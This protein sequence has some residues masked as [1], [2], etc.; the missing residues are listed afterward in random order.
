[1]A[2]DQIKSSIKAACGLEF[3]DDKETLLT[4]ALAERMQAT[5]TASGADYLR[6][7]Q[8]S[9]AELAELI[10][11]VTINETYFFREPE[12]IQLLTESLLP[13]LMAYQSERPLRILSLGCS[14]GEEPYSL[15]MALEQQLGAKALTQEVHI[16]GADI[17]R[18]ALAKARIGIYGD[19]AFRGL[20]P[21]W[22]ERY[23][24]R[25]GPGQYQILP[26]LGAGV[27]FHYLNLLDEHWPRSLLEQDVVFFRNVSIYFDE[28]HRR[29]IQAQICKALRPDGIL[30][31]SATETLSNDFGLMALCQQEEIFFFR[32]RAPD[33]EGTRPKGTAP[34]PAAQQGLTQ[35]GAALPEPGRRPANELPRTTRPTLDTQR[36]LAQ[37]LEQARQGQLNEALALTQHLLALTDVEVQ[38]RLEQQRLLAS[39]LFLK[40]DF[41]AAERAIR[42]ALVEDDLEP[43][44]LFLLAQIQRW[45]EQRAAAMDSLK[46]VLYSQPNHWQA[47]FLLGECH[48]QQGQTEL[49]QRSYRRVLQL[50]QRPPEANPDPIQA[51]TELPVGK[52]ALL[53]EHRLAALALGPD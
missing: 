5:G 29:Q 31:M 47:H 32:N 25:L 21:E 15:A 13:E 20:A 2:L 17:D 22:G 28:P 11:L 18:K 52:L 7:I 33:P 30:F 50:L 9:K 34:A 38:A 39:L 14:H 19:F 3:Q 53:A 26:R 24:S 40:E 4:K 43:K 48:R 51:L 49:A 6:L 10:D 8:A 42:Q 44:A 37:A 12:Q 35:N 27:E 46:K 36:L 1:M 45:Q 41:S 16:Q 23:F